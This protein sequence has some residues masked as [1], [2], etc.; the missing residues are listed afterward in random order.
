M[1]KKR[2]L[3]ECSHARVKDKRIRCCHGHP[4]SL[5]SVDGSVDLKRLARGEP[6][7]LNICQA[8]GDFDCIGPPLPE[9]ERG[10]RNGRR[11]IKQGVN[12]GETLAVIVSPGSR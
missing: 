3:Y 4:F 7:S 12:S 10:W 2:T 9:A 5:K 6:L 11:P 1:K 8:C